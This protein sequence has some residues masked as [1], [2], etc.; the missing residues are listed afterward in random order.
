M[1]KALLIGI[2]YINT[3]I[4][5]NG[6]ISDIV[7][8]NEVLKNTYN[9]D[10]I[11]MLR[12]DI[13]IPSLLPTRNNILIEL[14]KL[15]SD[16]ANCTEIWIHYSGHGSRVRDFNGDEQ[17]GYDSVI[18]PLNYMSAGYIV[19]DDLYNI[20][21]RSKCKTIILMDSCNSGSVIDLPWSYTLVSP[22]SYMRSLNNRYNLSNPQIFM[23]SGCKDNQTS[24]DVF[25]IR[26]GQSVGAFTDSFLTCLK[27][28]N[29]QIPLLMLYRNVCIYLNQN[30]F[31]QRPVYSSSSSNPSDTNAVLLLPV[32]APTIIKRAL[33]NIISGTGITTDI[34]KTEITNTDIKKPGISK[35]IGNPIITTTKILMK[36]NE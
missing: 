3:N 33:N 24:A 1:K 22:T 36:Y 18:V 21:K 20:I 14:Q 15:I 34:V 23:F 17:S 16:S 5:L 25:S 13:Q 11:T 35:S 7:N 10:E 31:S 28:A 4:S 6:C 8:M 32:Q 9:Y 30:R 29:Y 27:H 2:N 12:D 19:D 26:L